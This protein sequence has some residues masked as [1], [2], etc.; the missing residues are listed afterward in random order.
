MHTFPTFSAHGVCDP[1]HGVLGSLKWALLSWVAGCF[2][3]VSFLTKQGKILIHVSS[4][5]QVFVW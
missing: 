1:T 5:F 3:L 2:S 4:V